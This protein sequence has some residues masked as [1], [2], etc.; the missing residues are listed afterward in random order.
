[1]GGL[2]GQIFFDTDIFKE[3][4]FKKTPRKILFHSSK[5]EYPLNTYLKV[6]K[7]KFYSECNLAIACNSNGNRFIRT[8]LRQQESVSRSKNGYAPIESPLRIY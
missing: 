8:F 6:T 4:Y 3:T 1:M 7:T 5:H 2:T